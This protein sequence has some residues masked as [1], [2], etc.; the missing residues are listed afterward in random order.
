MCTGCTRSVVGGAL[1]H[2]FSEASPLTLLFPPSQPGNVKLEP[3]IMGTSQALVKGK[4]GEGAPEKVSLTEARAGTG[5]VCRVLTPC[6]PPSLCSTCFT[7]AL[8]RRRP[9]LR[10]P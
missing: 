4:L 9:R 5:D 10:R 8:A 6:G 3:S 2:C 1:C 7:A